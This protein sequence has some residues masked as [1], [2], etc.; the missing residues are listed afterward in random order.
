MSE[1]EKTDKNAELLSPYV[2]VNNNYYFEI[3]LYQRIFEW[4]EENIKQL[5]QDLW[6]QYNKY[7]SHSQK[8]YIGAFTCINKSPSNESPLTFELLDGQQRITALMI[9]ASVLYE[10]G[11]YEQ[12]RNFIG[13]KDSFRIHY[14]SRPNDE[15]KLKELCG[16]GDTES[17]KSLNTDNSSDDISRMKRCKDG[18]EEFLKE[19]GDKLEDF[20]EY[21]YHNLTIIKTSLPADYTHQDIFQYFDRFNTPSPNL[22]NYEIVKFKLLEGL[23]KDQYLYTK[24]LEAAMNMDKPLIRKRANK[25]N[26]ESI[27]K[28]FMNAISFACNAKCEFFT[29][30]G[31]STL[32]DVYLT[33]EE[34]KDN[35]DET[36]NTVSPF[37]DLLKKLFEDNTKDNEIKKEEEKENNNFFSTPLFMLLTLY[38]MVIDPS[39]NEIENYGVTKFFDKNKII[40]TFNHFFPEIVKPEDEQC[41]KK[42]FIRQ[43]VLYR[44]LLDK[45]FIIK[46]K[47]EHYKLNSEL[48]NTDDS[49]ES[50]EK[51][52]QYEAML[53]YSHYEGNYYKWLVPFFKFIKDKNVQ[54]AELLKK[55]KSIDNEN[56]TIEEKTIIDKIK[57]FHDQDNVEKFDA[58]KY[59]KNNSR[60]WFYR[61]D[62]Y[63]WEEYKNAHNQDNTWSKDLDPK[64]GSFIDGYYFRAL[65][66]IEHVDPQTPDTKDDETNKLIDIDQFG[67]LALIS[68]S[69]NSGLGRQSYRQKIGKIKDRIESEKYKIESLKL[70]HIFTYS[71]NNS[72]WNNDNCKDHTKKMINVLHRSFDEENNTEVSN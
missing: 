52:K 14:A 68:S 31:N 8:Y 50:K 44:L 12:W 36:K 25:E 19:K 55:L 29:N 71:L 27:N 2:I 9:I 11:K 72:P 46:D 18:V 49:A 45:Y 34:N 62:Y 56:V 7:N 48:L 57:V 60:Y 16:L 22:E 28:R 70:L 33:N 5:L 15:N 24:L 6:T 67:N 42:E 10:K 17:Q 47:D 20:S 43:L 37:F 38:I 41:K 39:E 64:I 69:T 13:K 59:G 32:N 51:L 54:S 3:P 21:I 40:E 65:R 4:E 35:N 53:F 61:L 26:N 1:Q 63:L 23:G 30:Y 66:S 58:L